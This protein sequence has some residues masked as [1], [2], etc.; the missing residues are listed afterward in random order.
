MTREITNAEVSVKANPLKISATAENPFSAKNGTSW[1]GSDAA[2]SHLVSWAGP[3][4]NQ[5]SAR[6]VEVGAGCTHAAV[7]KSGNIVAICGPLDGGHQVVYL[8]SVDQRILARANLPT[9]TDNL[10]K[11]SAPYP[12]ILDQNDSLLVGAPDQKIL[13]ISFSEADPAGPKVE[14]VV[15]L[16]SFKGAE[17]S[18]R[19]ED[20]GISA[21][22]ID[23]RGLIWFASE[24]GAV[25]FFDPSHQI[26][27]FSRLI[28]PKT[29]EPELI[30]NHLAIS[31]DNAIFAVT[32]HAL[33][34]IEKSSVG[35]NITIVWKEE[36]ERGT[37]VKKGQSTQGSG[38]G[39]LLVGDDFV[40]IGDN[41]DIRMSVMV[42]R[43]STS[44]K[45]QR[46]FCEQPVFKIRSS[47]GEVAM[48]AA[49]S[50]IIV[51]NTFG[52]DGPDSVKDLASSEAG[53][54]R[55]DLNEADGNCK[56][57]WNRPVAV[58][59]LSPIVSID[60]GLI[61]VYAKKGIGWYLIAVEFESG[62]PSFDIRVG[63]TDAYVAEN[64]SLLITPVGHALVTHRTGFSYIGQASFAQQ[65]SES[66]PL[67][68]DGKN[69]K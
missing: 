67:L 21:L 25:G 66:M 23:F 2:A 19:P 53:L 61:Y 41:R 37:T 63:G 50:S 17:K 8:N 64:G 16:R 36:F 24:N 33:Y 51:Q 29:V 40:A 28:D 49:G 60:S 9:P 12:S 35:D 65:Q 10:L 20:G 32:T 3:M 43:R 6:L 11:Y 27:A 18:L 30:T 22:S 52:Y 38:T 26:G 55:I 1:N 48:A 7:I 69:Q 13:R 47:A 42:Y 14:E 4:S 59:N 58:P 15:D 56:I 31:P 54:I 34:R 39:P 62:H 44:L 45:S 57:A 68:L 46:K 5:L